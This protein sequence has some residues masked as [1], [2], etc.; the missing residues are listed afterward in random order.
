MRYRVYKSSINTYRVW[1][2]RTGEFVTDSGFIA[3]ASVRAGRVYVGD[4]EGRFY[5]LAAA[6]GNITVH[7]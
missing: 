4:F 7:R 2:A 6:D 5:C 1:D 3:S